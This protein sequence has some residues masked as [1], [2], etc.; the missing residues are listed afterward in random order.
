MNDFIISALTEINPFNTTS[1]VIDWLRGQNMRIKVD[2]T[3]VKFSELQGWHF[4]EHSNLRH[5]TGKFFSI[6]GIDVVTNW[7]NVHHWRQPI[8][9]QPEIGYLGI[10]TKKIDGILY[11]LLQAKVEPGNINNVQLSPTIQA[12]KSNYTQAHGG[13]KP[14]YLEYFQGATKE[15]IRLDQLQSEQGARFLRKRNR[16]IIIQIQD[17][18][19]PLYDNFIWLTLGQI[20]KLAKID[21]L[22]NMDTRT[23]ISG[24]PFFTN[25]EDHV[26]LTGSS[27]FESDML[28]SCLSRRN[29]LYTKTQI[30]SWMTSLKCQYDLAVKSI[31]IKDVDD[32][33]VGDYK[34]SHKDNKFFNVI[35]AKV[36]ISNRE[37]KTWYQP[38]VQP[39]QQGL[40]AFL[41]KKING[42]YHF[43]VQAK[44][45]SGNFDVVEMAPTVQCLTGSYYDSANTLPFLKNVL[46]AAPEQIRIDTL[47][48]EEGGRFW[49]EQNRNVIIEVSDDFSEDVP[50]NYIWMTLNQLITFLEFNNYLNIQARSLISLINFI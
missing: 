40:V 13:N 20:K 41:V 17:D 14:L 50:S 35:A 33:T 4:D 5:D 18:D 21:N 16:N 49:Q 27:S 3:Q 9:N 47:Q 2:V 43:L 44:V 42:V 28:Q 26:V 38:L 36:A 48:S 11:F 37:V 19:L 24:I 31:D 34:I 25:I 32:W 6:E 29:S 12:T 8:I 45:E 39:V 46:E 30:L 15:Q 23:V 1:Q 7:G 10:I 22:V